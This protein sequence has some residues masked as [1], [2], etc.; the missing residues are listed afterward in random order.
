MRMPFSKKE[1]LKDNR[2]MRGEIENLVACNAELVIMMEQS[3][4]LIEEANLRIDK[5][6]KKVDEKCSQ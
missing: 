3:K 2:K 1:L 4:A 6:N 5:Y